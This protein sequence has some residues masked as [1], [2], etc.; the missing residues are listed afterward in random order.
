MGRGNDAARRA[1]A[2]GEKQKKRD[3]VRETKKHALKARED[4]EIGKWARN[5]ALRWDPTSGLA[6]LAR[7]LKDH[8]VVA[9][10]E[11]GRLDEVA[12]LDV[13]LVGPRAVLWRDAG[14]LR[15]AASRWPSAWALTEATFGAPKR[16][17]VLRF[18]LRYLE[19][20][21]RWSREASGLAS[22]EAL[23]LRALGRAPRGAGSPPLALG[24]GARREGAAPDLGDQL[25]LAGALDRVQG[26]RSEGPLDAFFGFQAFSRFVAAAIG[27]L[28][29][30]EALLSGLPDLGP[31]LRGLA[32]ERRARLLE[33]ALLKRPAD[34][35][36]L[37][38]ATQGWISVA[39]LRPVEPRLIVAGAQAYERLQARGTSSPA[40]SRALAL[41][42][43]LVEG[44]ARAVVDE[45]LSDAGIR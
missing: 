9:A 27:D 39:E 26:A 43:A 24:Q 36:A 37:A 42:A 10:L 12:A 17:E 21:E 19:V 34:E 15:E 14:E 2:K 11:A 3:V 28:G 16:A 41:A 35:A 13:A 6:D 25:L 18:D 8:P 44:S 22:T 23:L 45:A 4:R 30:I 40:L 29:F 38:A 7:R 33:E 5:E 1:R 32:V 31:G 20:L